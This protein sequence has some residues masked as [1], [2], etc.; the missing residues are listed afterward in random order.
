MKSVSRSRAR[1]TPTDMGKSG[2]FDFHEQV[3]A[4][5]PVALPAA[6]PTPIVACASTP[7]DAGPQPITV[8][9]LTHRIDRALKVG[10]PEVVHV[11][12][13]ISNFRPNQASGHVYFTLKDA[14][15]CIDCVMWKS[16]AVR[17]KF[18]PADG[19]ELLASGKVGVY[20]IR[21]KYQLY[22]TTLRP[23]GKGALELAFQQLRTKLEAEGLF[24]GQ[25]KRAAARLSDDGGGAGDSA[26]H[27][28]VAGCFEG[29]AAV[30]VDST[31][32]LSRSGAGTGRSAED[33]RGDFTFEPARAR[34]WRAN[35]ACG[36]G[37]WFLGRPVGV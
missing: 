32:A 25:R 33:C 15:S 34:A 2:F 9:E 21:G 31:A 12:G 6:A 28:R 35:C 10:V 37:R 20:G 36:A 22:V 14:G 7:A 11:R 4:R 3:R 16:D 26:G 8:S 23:L 19:I 5:R 1:Y 27:R 17:L 29:A 18:T 30:R 24:A 13:E